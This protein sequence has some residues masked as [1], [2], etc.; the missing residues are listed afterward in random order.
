MKPSRWQSRER[1]VK[2]APELAKVNVAFAKLSH[3]HQTET[4]NA[5][6]AR[7]LYSISSAK[8]SL[9]WPKLWIPQMRVGNFVPSSSVVLHFDGHPH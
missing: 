1:L 9:H 8:A 5:G 7:T 4:P 3:L 2:P 6:G